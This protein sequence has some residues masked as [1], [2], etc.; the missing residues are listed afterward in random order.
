MR[1]GT[2]WDNVV[3]GLAYK[4]TAM[5]GAGRKEKGDM[6]QKAGNNVGSETEK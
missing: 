3:K 6:Q 4:G 2:N 5:S 1:L